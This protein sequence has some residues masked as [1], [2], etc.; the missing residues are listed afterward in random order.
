[1]FIFNIVDFKISYEILRNER[2]IKIFNSYKYVC[3][4]FRSYIKL[5]LLDI[6][7]DFNIIIMDGIIFCYS[8][9]IKMVFLGL[10]V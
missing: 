10:Y 7:I 9:N 4:R 1:M 2:L 3:I 8:M 6:S 5:I